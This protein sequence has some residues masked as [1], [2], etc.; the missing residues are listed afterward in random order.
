MSNN[1]Y[2]SLEDVNIPVSSSCEIKVEKPAVAKASV[3]MNFP[4][5]GIKLSALRALITDDVNNLSGLT[6]TDVCMKI[7]SPLTL[8]RRCSYI[9]LQKYL[10]NHHLIGKPA[11]FVSHAWRYEFVRVVE[12]LEAHVQADDDQDPFVWFDLCGNSQHDTSDRPMEWWKTTFL[13]AI[14]DIGRTVMIMEPWEDP[15]PLTRAWCV[16]EVLCTCQTGAKFEIAMTKPQRDR[17]ISALKNEYG[18]IMKMVCRI[19]CRRAEAWKESDRAGIMECVETTIGFV[20]MNATVVSCVRA[21]ILGMAR[22][23]IGGL[24]NDDDSAT[25]ANDLMITLPAVPRATSMKKSKVVPMNYSVENDVTDEEK[26]SNPAETVTTTPSA[27]ERIKARERSQ[28]RIDCNFQTVLAVKKENNNK[29]PAKSAAQGVGGRPTACDAC[30]AAPPDTSASASNN[31]SSIRIDSRL[32]TDLAVETVKLLRDQNHLDDAIHLGYRC[33]NARE[34]Y[35]PTARQEIGEHFIEKTVELMVVI[36]DILYEI[37]SVNEATKLV[38]KALKLHGSLQRAR[39]I[40]RLDLQFCQ[41]ALRVNL[42]RRG[43]TWLFLKWLYNFRKIGSH[44]WKVFISDSAKRPGLMWMARN[45]MAGMRLQY[46]YER[47]LEVPLGKPKF[48][49]V[50]K[51]FLQVVQEEYGNVH[52]TTILGMLVVGRELT[53][54]QTPEGLL[55]AVE[56]LRAAVD[57]ATVTMGKTRPELVSAMMGLAACYELQGNYT[58]AVTVYSAAVSGCKDVL[59]PRSPF[60]GLCGLARCQR[61][62]GFLQASLITLDAAQGEGKERLRMQDSH[63][64]LMALCRSRAYTMQ[65]MAAD[66]RADMQEQERKRLSGRTAALLKKNRTRGIRFQNIII[67]GMNSILFNFLGA[68]SSS[69][70]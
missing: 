18:S 40:D 70:E 11:M 27:P 32:I 41:V 20:Q 28:V 45:F 54:L 66:P 60:L 38:E 67:D 16:W 30:T 9:E 10:G 63:P 14:R 36:A 68:P 13:E 1:T 35:A 4:K 3:A 61:K 33:L 22:C 58:Q 50:F 56:M 69:N 25:P 5:D 48:L 23:E 55:Q 8:E 43:G 34:L 65:A 64:L 21:W 53:K 24:D 37:Q 12:A 46:D 2:V 31:S 26:A 39:V 44:R 57:G 15:I 47:H 6:T 7:V 29:Q 52:P 62:A 59:P 51:A 49:Q 42:G 17:F 19:D